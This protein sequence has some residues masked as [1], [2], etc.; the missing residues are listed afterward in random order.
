MITHAR[1]ARKQRVARGRSLFG[2]TTRKAATSPTTLLFPARFQNLRPSTSGSSSL[3][4]HQHSGSKTHTAIDIYSSGTLQL[5]QHASSKV[6]I[7]QQQQQQKVNGP[8]PDRSPTV[9]RTSPT[10]RHPVP[11]AQ[12]SLQQVKGSSETGQSRFA[13]IAY[14]CM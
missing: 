13:N 8:R 4:R 14:V 3:Q 7:S 6:L 11:G 9:L 10:D 12:A 2:T 5:H 1:T